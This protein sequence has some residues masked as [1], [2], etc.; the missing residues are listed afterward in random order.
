MQPFLHATCVF[1]LE[2]RV[3]RDLSC[4]V[5]RLIKITCDLERRHSLHHLAI[6]PSVYPHLS[7]GP[8]L[9]TFMLGKYH[10]KSD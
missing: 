1:D 3:S 10:L 9:H 4:I 5:N 8:A 2:P 6:G 7:A